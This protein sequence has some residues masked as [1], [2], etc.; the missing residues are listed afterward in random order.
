MHRRDPNQLT[1]R[2]HE[3]LELLRR[4]FTNEQI[5]R[6]LGISVDGAKYHVS[7][8]L[9]KLG[10][11]TREEAA[12]VALSERRRWWVAWP[13]WGKIA[14][15]ATVA[16]AVAGLAV[17]AWGVVRTGGPDERTVLSQTERS[18]LIEAATNAVHR[19]GMVF[20]AV[21][22]NGSELWIDGD[23]Q[24]FRQQAGKEGEDGF[25]VRVGDGWKTTRVDVSTNQLVTL[26]LTSRVDAND[27]PVFN[28]IEPLRALV[29]AED[30]SITKEKFSAGHKI[31]VLEATTLVPFEDHPEGVPVRW[32]VELDA[33]SSLI[34]AYEGGLPSDVR[35]QFEGEGERV[36]YTTLEFIDPTKLPADFFSPDV[37]RASIST[38]ERRV[39][40]IEALGISVYWLGERLNTEG[41]TLSILDPRSNISADEERREGSL[42]YSFRAGQVSPG[43][44]RILLRPAG[45][46]P[47]GPPD[48]PETSE[49]PEQEDNVTVQGREAIL[50]TSLLRAAGILCPA[51]TPCGPADAA[52]YHRLVVVF[53]D[54][55]IQLEAIGGPLDNPFNDRD[56]LLA[57]AEFLK[58]A[59]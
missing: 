17:L 10:V 49:Q 15:A 27:H 39:Q 9:S 33:D 45:G 13:L 28:W 41:G 4:D 1:D 19:P 6:R 34:Q 47:F 44:V 29:N 21:S 14:G 38:A 25:V 48:I 24:L 59:N 57:L 8:I 22:K 18:T 31:I 54:A 16:A 55:A 46:I 2:E 37:V 23:R 11:A 43:G 35:R 20:H 7:Q 58:P 30:L 50:Y 40:Q 32:S 12:A 36:E 56:A 53:D 3:V 52:L 26:D 5:A 42:Y 51:G